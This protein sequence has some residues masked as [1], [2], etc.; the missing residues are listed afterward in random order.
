MGCFQ[1]LYLKLTGE[2][3]GHYYFRGLQFISGDVSEYQEMYE[4]KL[5]VLF[6]WFWHE[7]IDLQEENVLKVTSGLKVGI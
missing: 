3:D 5:M 7:E 2:H 6:F 1:P 4:I